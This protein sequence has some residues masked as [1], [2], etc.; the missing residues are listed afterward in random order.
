MCV[1]ATQRHPVC[2]LSGFVCVYACGYVGGGITGCETGDKPH[3]N[4][5]SLSVTLILHIIETCLSVYALC[6]HSQ[7]IRCGEHDDTMGESL[8]KM[9]SLETLLNNTELRGFKAGRD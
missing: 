7:R 2:I 9:V 3:G 5:G 1:N 4:G 8:R 6:S